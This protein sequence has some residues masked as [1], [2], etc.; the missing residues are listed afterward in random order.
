MGPTKIT[1]KVCSPKIIVGTDG[2]L[3]GWCEVED[4]GGE[5]HLPVESALV[6]H[7]LL[8]GQP[9]AVHVEAVKVSV[10]HQISLTPDHIL[11][12]L[13]LLFFPGENFLQRQLRFKTYMNLPV[14]SRQYQSWRNRREKPMKTTKEKATATA[15]SF[16]SPFPSKITSKSFSRL[17]CFVSHL[18]FFSST[19][20][21]TMQTPSEQLLAKRTNVMFCFI[22]P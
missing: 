5:Q 7:R 11:S 2:E 17:F 22:V 14:F 8:H 18:P 9:S 4:G 10:G 6:H 20:C 1:T 19:S 15:F 3:Q 16:L 13:K 12:R 21:S